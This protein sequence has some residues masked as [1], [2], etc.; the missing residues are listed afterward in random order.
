MMLRYVG[1]LI[2][3]GVLVFA[4][5]AA[6]SQVTPPPGTQRQRREL[7]HRLRMGFQRSIHSSRRRRYSLTVFSSVVAW[8]ASIPRARFGS[9]SNFFV[10]SINGWKFSL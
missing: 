4:P 2:L 7:E 9:A 5:L 6:S 1:S 8:P 3:A 10:S